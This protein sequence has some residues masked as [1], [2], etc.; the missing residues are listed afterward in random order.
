MVLIIYKNNYFYY[1]YGRE[2]GGE[3][4]EAYEGFGRERGSY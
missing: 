2:D 1:L 4:D 3:W